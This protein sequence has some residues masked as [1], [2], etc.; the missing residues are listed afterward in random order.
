[1]LLLYKQ[2]EKYIYGIIFKYMYVRTNLQKSQ[3]ISQVN[4]MDNT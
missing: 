3:A 4:K 1:M 2:R